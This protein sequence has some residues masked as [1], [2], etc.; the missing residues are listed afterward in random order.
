MTRNTSSFYCRVLPSRSPRFCLTVW[1]S[2]AQR[3]KPSL[4]PV[5]IRAKADL[6]QCGLDGGKLSR[7]SAAI[8]MKNPEVSRHVGRLLHCEE[9]AESIQACS[10]STNLPNITNY[11][12][13]ILLLPSSGRFEQNFWMILAITNRRATRS[14]N[15]CNQSWWYSG[16]KIDFFQGC[17]HPW[18][19]FWTPFDCRAVVR[20]TILPATVLN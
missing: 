18:C 15:R 16:R 6:K 12:C 8:L 19:V 7:D 1:M 2:E 14:T 5:L 11:Q 9:W 17:M 20:N 13:Q 4:S 3:P 10:Q